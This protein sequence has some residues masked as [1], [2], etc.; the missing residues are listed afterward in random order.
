VDLFGIYYFSVPN[1]VESLSEKA[2]SKV[3]ACG[4]YCYA[5]AE[6]TNELYAWGMGENYVL[7]TREDDNEFE[8]KL[9]NPM[10]F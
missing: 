1:C 3:F 6:P 9:V 5:L 10:Q 7:G 8:P 2:I 4:H